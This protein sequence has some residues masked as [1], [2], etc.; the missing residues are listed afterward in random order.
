MHSNGE[1]IP[2]KFT[3]LLLLSSLL[4]SEAAK[5]ASVLSSA[6]AQGSITQSDTKQNASCTHDTFNSCCNGCGYSF[7]SKDELRQAVEEFGLDKAAATE[8]YGIMNCWDVSWITDMSYLFSNYTKST[9]DYLLHEFNEPVDC[10]DV[11][12]VYNMFA[13]L[14]EYYSLPELH[15]KQKKY[16]TLSLYQQL[17]SYPPSRSR[18]YQNR[19][20]SLKTYHDPS[21]MD[22]TNET[23]ATANQLKTTPAAANLVT[24]NMKN[25]SD[26]AAPEN[27]WINDTGISRLS[28]VIFNQLEIDRRTKRM[29]AMFLVIP[30]LATKIRLFKSSLKCPPYNT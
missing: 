12:R 18:T 1:K 24:P 6:T 4:S 22:E 25:N 14:K 2:M 9:N 16:S 19:Y 11:S 13:R 29:R 5:N 21:T 8:K 3:T 26:T 20:S 17:L 10:W 28:E 23:T 15:I 27:L 30:N 7:T